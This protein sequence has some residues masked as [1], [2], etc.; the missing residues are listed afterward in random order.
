MDSLQEGMHQSVTDLLFIGL[1][2]SAEMLQDAQ[3][4]RVG[5]PVSSLNK[6]FT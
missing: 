4:T 3:I 2:I 5:T 6:Y 1:K